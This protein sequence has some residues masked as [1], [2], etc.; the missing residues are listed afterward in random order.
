[1]GV[2]NSRLSENHMHAEH[3]PTLLLCLQATIDSNGKVLHWASE[4]AVL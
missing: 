3:P 1:M 4:P 2:V